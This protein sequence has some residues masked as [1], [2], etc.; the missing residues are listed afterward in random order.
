MLY[1]MKISRLFCQKLHFVAQLFEFHGRPKKS[2]LDFVVVVK[3]DI[4]F[5]LHV[6]FSK[7]LLSVVIYKQIQKR[8][9]FSLLMNIH[10][11]Q[12]ALLQQYSSK[13]L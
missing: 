1:Y 9:S 2:R 6:L 10:N 13:Q 5:E 8:R 12:K 11:V 7:S 3:V 4:L